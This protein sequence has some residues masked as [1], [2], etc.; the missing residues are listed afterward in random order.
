MIIYRIFKLLQFILK[1]Y[2]SETSKTLFLTSHRGRLILMLTDL[3]E[4]TRMRYLTAEKERSLMVFI[5]A[6]LVVKSEVKAQWLMFVS[7]H[8]L[9]RVQ[10]VAVGPKKDRCGHIYRRRGRRQM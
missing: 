3:G 6:S 9:Y 10:T 1:L 8:E 7:S 4:L 2:H 5:T